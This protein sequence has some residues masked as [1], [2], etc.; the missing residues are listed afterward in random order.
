MPIRNMRTAAGCAASV[1]LLLSGLAAGS[2]ALASQHAC[3]GWAVKPSPSVGSA[4]LGAVASASAKDVWAVG[5]YSTGSAYKTLIEHWNGARWTI[6]SSP[7]PATGFHTTNTLGAVVAIAPKNA[8]AFGFYE[9]Q[10][11]SFRTLVEHWDGTKWS[12][13]PSPNA[14]SGENALQAAVARNAG[15]IWAVGYRNDPGHR[16]TLTEHWN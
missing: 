14:G 9:K 13:V 11:T 4:T 1:V 2:P 10:T 15:D 8:W 5:S 7:N 6:V 16:R 3:V 12:V